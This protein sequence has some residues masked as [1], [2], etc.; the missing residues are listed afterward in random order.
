MSK[1]AQKIWFSNGYCMIYKSKSAHHVEYYY[2]LLKV[3]FVE[4][5]K[6]SIYGILFYYVLFLCGFVHEFVATLDCEVG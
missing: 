4:D 5:M 2:R 3:S 1:N 6:I